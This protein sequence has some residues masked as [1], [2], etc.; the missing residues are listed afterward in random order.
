MAEDDDL[1]QALS[2]KNLPGLRSCLERNASLTEIT[3]DGWTPLHLA[4]L[5]ELP[6]GA[7]LLLQFGADINARTPQ[8]RTP[9]HDAAQASSLALVRLLLAHGADPNAP[10]RRGLTP[11]HIAGREAAPRAA[12]ALTFRLLLDG[13]ADP[14][15]V[16]AEGNRPLHTLRSLWAGRR[17]TSY[18]IAR[19]AD[20]HARN[21][22]GQTP[23]HMGAQHCGPSVPLLIRHGADVNARDTW[24]GWTPLHGAASSSGADDARRLLGAG[25]EIDARDDQGRTPL[26][27]AV[28]YSC[29]NVADVLLA[30][31]SDVNARDAEG[32]TPLFRA[33]RCPFL[34][35]VEDGNDNL[36]TLRL[37]RAA[38]RQKFKDAGG[39]T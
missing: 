27:I 1:F 2:S 23:L 39:R 25:A 30:A 18:L 14:N 15:A 17:P 3:L 4:I 20:V 28:L 8:G 12:T 5:W 38:M 22:L 16:D 9:L 29:L 13:G 31:G 21:E 24:A 26:H 33:T 10:D 35:R 6:E 34:E 11:L 37:L 32:K 19:G 7:E 36:K